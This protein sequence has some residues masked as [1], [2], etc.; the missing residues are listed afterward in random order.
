MLL[1]IVF[2]TGSSSA[3]FAQATGTI[4]GTLSGASGAVV[5]AAQ[6]GITNTGT[7]QTRY[8]AADEVRPVV[9]ASVACWQLQ[10]AHRKAKKTGVKPCVGAGCILSWW[11]EF[12]PRSPCRTG[13]A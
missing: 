10:R 2:L 5:P 7:N 6:I 3:L 8:V 12:Q 4:Y 13:G 9:R 11:P 1:R